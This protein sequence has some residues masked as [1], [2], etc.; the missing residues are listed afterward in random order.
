MSL[1]SFNKKFYPSQE[2]LDKCPMRERE[3][4]NLLVGANI[5][6]MIMFAIF[7][8]VLFIFNYF[9]IGIGGILLLAFFIT[10]LFYVKK[11]HI[12]LASWITSVAI[13]V[14]SVIECYGSPF[15]VSN[16]LPYRDSCFIAVMS[17]CNYVVSLRRRQLH[18]FFTAGMGLWFVTNATR[19][20]PIY[21]A[22]GKTAVMNII[23]CSLAIIVSN[24]CILLFDSFTRRVVEHAEENEKKSTHAFS[25]LSN[26]INETKEG[27]NI[28]K[29]LAESTGKAASSVSEISDLYTY[30]N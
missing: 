15:A 5:V 16:Y 9:V 17:I 20:R 6:F 25:K 14:I 3:Q 26:V 1:N 11:G 18:I 10:S 22:N 28:G 12:H 4:L 8:L 13:M 29:Q 24:I 7:G 27:L 19:Y 30:I 23:I 2:F 21:V